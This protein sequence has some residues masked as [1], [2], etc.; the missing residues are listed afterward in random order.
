MAI[1]LVGVA[2]A[3]Q[4]KE[5]AAERVA[6][7]EALIGTE[8]TVKPQTP[9]RVLVFWRCEGYVH[10]DSIALGN[11]ALEIAAR[12]TSAFKV[13]FSR[14]YAALRAE[15]LAQYDTLVLNNTTNLKTDAPENS[16]LVSALLDFV[17]GGKGLTLIHA[18]VDNFYR[19]EECASMTGGLFWGHP[20]G[21]GGTWAFKVEE[22]EHP[23]C[24]HSLKGLGSSFKFSDEIY[25][26][27]SPY[28]DR[29][30]L[31]VLVSLDLSDKVTAQAKGQLREDNDYAVS[32]VRRF[33]QGRV[34]YTSFAHDHRAWMHREILGH[35]LDGLQYTL[36]DL[37]ADDTPRGE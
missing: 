6:A 5:P 32:W 20:W 16:F 31:R 19:A 33:G 12:K 18:A 35:I 27:K 28:Y 17:R 21:A 30:K 10:G 14:D 15:N 37:K 26:H 24:V 22:P 13:D 9:R 4:L 7:V 11:K 3:Q 8:L 25:Q 36:G 29:T 34:F 2:S 23:C 1:L